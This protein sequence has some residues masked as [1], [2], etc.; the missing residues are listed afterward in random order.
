[1]SHSPLSSQKHRIRHEVRERIATMS[2]NDR[3]E[4]DARLVSLVA[5][6]PGLDRS[7]T[8]L[9]YIGALSEEIDTVPLLRN[10]LGS[11][12]RLVL[13]RVDRAARRL[14]LHA[15]DDLERGMVRSRMGIPEPAPDSRQVDPRE[16]DWVLVPGLAFD[17]HCRRIGR[18]AGHY[19][20]LLTE[21]RDDT[22]GWAIAY[23]CQII[24]EVP[25]GPHDQTID[26]VLTPSNRWESPA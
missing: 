1:M 2:A 21:V 19:D 6:L 4:A 13:P 23:D 25:I 16:V 10:W 18:G 7:A 15:V 26:G 11:G 12:K 8:V 14:T 22:I 24:D 17:R 20:R 3:R 9:G 5:D